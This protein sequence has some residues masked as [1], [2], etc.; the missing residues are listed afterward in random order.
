MKDEKISESRKESIAETILSEEIKHS[1]VSPDK[2]KEQAKSVSPTK[3]PSPVQEG[4]PTKSPS[5][6][7]EDSPERK[8]GIIA[9]EEQEN[10]ELKSSEYT[11]VYDY[12]HP[13][14]PQYQ[15][16]LRETHITTVESPIVEK[17]KLIDLQVIDK[18]IT[19]TLEGDELVLNDI[20]EED[21]DRISPPSGE[22]QHLPNIIAPL[23]V[24]TEPPRAVSPRE[25][26]VL[27]IV[28][29][30]AEILK[31]EKDI[32]ELLP[33]FDPDE[34]EKNIM[35][36]ASTPDVHSLISQEMHKELEIES[37]LRGFVDPHDLSASL[38]DA[39]ISIDEKE[40]HEVAEKHQTLLHE[41]IDSSELNRKE[42]CVSVVLDDSR[43]ESAISTL[44]EKI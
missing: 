13:F 43:R 38:S 9:G 29:N 5:P 40:Q 27:K 20:K 14:D 18:T 15:Q 25:Q 23:D 19:E 37:E 12:S 11:D 2:E 22:L 8:E 44:S 31:S 30:V 33:D 32:V 42:S 16:E 28:V 10:L 39:K 17:S 34:L 1:S 21:E 4:L 3:S 41:T 26:E 35:Q 6:V 7:K 36:R 24:Q